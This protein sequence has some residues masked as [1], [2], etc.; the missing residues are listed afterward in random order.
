[1]TKSIPVNNLSDPTRRDQWGRY[2]VVPPIGGKPIGYT[3]VT[4]VAKVLDPGGGLI[5][6]KAT[7]TACGMI[8]RR[9]LRS[10]WESLIAQYDDPWYASEA[11]KEACKA[12]VEECAA[13]GGANDRAEMGTSLHDITAMVDRGR[14][15]QHLTPETEADIAA[16]V[17]G[18]QAAGI[19]FDPSLIEVTVVLDEW[20]TAGK[21][22]R[23]AHVPGFELPLVA[24]LK[25]GANLDYS[26]Q[27]FAVQ[28]AGYSRGNA[29]YEQG[30]ALDGTADKRHPMIPVDQNNGLIMWLNAGTGTLELYLVDLERGW[31]AF[32]QSMWTRG[33]RK[34]VVSQPFGNAQLKL[35]TATEPDSLVPVLQASID[36]IEAAKPKRGRPRKTPSPPAAIE[37][38]ATE[39]PKMTKPA[40]AP[41]PVIVD[42]QA[43]EHYIDKVRE[44]L[45]DRINLIGT[46]DTAR[47]DLI[48]SWPP[49]MPTLMGSTAH[50]PDQ[51]AAIEKLLVGVEARAKMPFGALKPEPTNEQMGRLLQMFPQSTL[52]TNNDKE[53]PA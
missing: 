31:H 26:W 12:L 32:K 51:L 43:G 14:M 15:P 33:W 3:R 24:D 40:I 37:A 25:T 38:A 39:A 28:L 45:Q 53:H 17:E 52:I 22:D 1:M 41:E 23:V 49:D 21:F 9:G 16:Y 47:A 35:P 10:Q 4:T 42:Y 50:T 7:M 18:L 30:P 44:W 6:W 13:V 5:P 20:Q 34:E 19:S 27:S 2:L 46:H 11:T 29:I 36:A 48:R 8:L